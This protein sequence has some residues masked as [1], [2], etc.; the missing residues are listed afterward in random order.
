MRICR[1][2]SILMWLLNGMI[3]FAGLEF[4]EKEI[5]DMHESLEKWREIAR[6]ANDLPPDV[7]IPLLGRG[8]YK[9]S[10]TDIYVFGDREGVRRELQEALVAIPG[11]AEWYHREILQKRE[12]ALQGR[13][14]LVKGSVY[15]DFET[16]GNMPS[17]ESVKV[18]GSFLEACPA[19]PAAD[20]DRDWPSRSALYAAIAFHIIGID[21]PPVHKRP[22]MV[23]P[24]DIRPW[25]LWY[26]QVKAGTRTFRFVGD[27][28]E[29]SLAGPVV[30]RETSGNPT[31]RRERGIREDVEPV[32]AEL[33]GRRTAWW[34]L[35]GS[36][37]VLGI[38]GWRWRRRGT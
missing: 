21:S 2:F 34:A 37:A 4:S 31:A 1:S 20:V 6:T 36:L 22:D 23:R 14:D 16:L 32:R 13:T 17:A 26:G 7:A 12:Y 5:A 18:L 9:T 30:A 15:W 33:P 8:V 27:P 29:Y 3:A 24:H 35:A 25:Q 10:Q 38:V 11:H 28:A 19:T